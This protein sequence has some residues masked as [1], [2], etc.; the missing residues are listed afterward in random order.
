[1]LPCTQMTADDVGQLFDMFATEKDMS[2]YSSS[3]EDISYAYDDFYRAA[4]EVNNYIGPLEI[5]QMWNL[6]LSSA[7]RLHSVQHHGMSFF[8]WKREL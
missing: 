4:E 3:G 7:R 1:M 5:I 8:Q 2:E 6:F